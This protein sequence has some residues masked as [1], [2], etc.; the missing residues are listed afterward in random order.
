M[1]D[2]APASEHDLDEVAD[3]IIEMADRLK[4]VDLTCP[5]A[6]ATWAFELDDIVFKVSMSVEK[7]LR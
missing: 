5:G 1:R 4:I 6:V 2:D 7:R 3:K